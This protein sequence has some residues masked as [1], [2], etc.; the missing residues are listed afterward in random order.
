[1]K[2]GTITTLYDLEEIVRTEGT[3]YLRYSEKIETQPGSI[4]G[5]SG[6]QLPGLS[7]NPLSPEAWWTR[8][9]KDWLARQICQYKH[10]GEKHGRHAWILSGDCVARGPDCEPLIDQVCPLGR[11]DQHLLDEA[12]QAYTKLFN[13]GHEP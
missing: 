12:E 10:I 11:L 7:V 9:L 2:Y 1:M 8:P 5:E 4:D 13:T 6:L 3:V